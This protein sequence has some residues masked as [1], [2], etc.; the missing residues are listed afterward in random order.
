M[1]GTIIQIVE[2][3]YILACIHCQKPQGEF[4]ISETGLWEMDEKYYQTCR[5]G[6]YLGNLSV[7]G[8]IIWKQILKKKG[9]QMLSGFNNLKW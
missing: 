9:P 4:I 7:Q 2:H 1:D 8:I 5:E 6:D 3:I